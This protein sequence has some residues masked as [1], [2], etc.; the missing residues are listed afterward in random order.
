MPRWDSNPQSQQAIGRRPSPETSRPV[1]SANCKTIVCKLRAID[2]I[3]YGDDSKFYVLLLLL[4]SML[5]MLNQISISET[6]YL[7]MLVSGVMWGTACRWDNGTVID[8]S[9][10]AVLLHTGWR[11]RAWELLVVNECNMRMLSGWVVATRHLPT[12]KSWR[13]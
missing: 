4:W 13:S 10:R 6:L 7:M 5:K 2:D 11:H 12:T 8:R 9:D 1:G 3:D